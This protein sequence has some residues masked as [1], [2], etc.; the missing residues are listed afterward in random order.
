MPGDQAR[1]SDRAPIRFSPRGGHGCHVPE[2]VPT[3]P[4]AAR[5]D[6]DAIRAWTARNEH[7]RAA[8]IARPD[9]YGSH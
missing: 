5:V 3:V 7:V 2:H 1:A 6:L 9:W 4:L 8:Y